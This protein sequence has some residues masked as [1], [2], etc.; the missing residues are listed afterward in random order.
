MKSKR[1]NV[2]LNGR[3]G[4]FRRLF[5]AFQEAQGKKIMQWGQWVPRAGSR[6]AAKK[7]CER[8]GILNAQLQAPEG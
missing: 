2:L 6:I 8:T 5:V 1:S 3:L 7:P 4:I